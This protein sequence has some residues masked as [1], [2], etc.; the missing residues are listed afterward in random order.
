VWEAGAGHARRF[1]RTRRRRALIGRRR[2]Q[3]VIRFAIL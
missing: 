1:A 2:V 3:A